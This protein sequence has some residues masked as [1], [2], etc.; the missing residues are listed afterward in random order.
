MIANECLMAT[1][2]FGRLIPNQTAL[3]ISLITEQIFSQEIS[4]QVPKVRSWV[5]T[6]V[7]RSN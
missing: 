7:G 5:G 2:T 4:F 6:W 1:E 3:A